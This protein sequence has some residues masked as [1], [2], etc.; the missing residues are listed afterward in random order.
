MTKI[1]DLRKKTKVCVIIP[2]LNEEKAVGEEID[3]VKDALKDYNFDIV[4]SDGRSSDNT[5]KIANQHGAKTIYQKRKGY[6]DALISGYLYS[7]QKLGAEILV[8]IDADGTYDSKD[9]PKMVDKI[10]LG[11]ADYVVGK[12]DVNTKSMTRSHILGNKVISWLIRSLLHVKVSD[13]QCGLF[14]FRSYLISEVEN[15]RTIGW[16]LNT[17]LLTKAAESEMIIQEIETAYTPRIGITHS[18]TLS[19]GAINLAVIIRMIIDFQPLLLLG[20]ISA[21]FFGLGLI[22]GSSVVYEFINSETITRSN[23]ATLSALFIITGIQILSLGIVADMI[24]RKNQKRI[25]PLEAYY[26][27]I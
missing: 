22:I 4:V 24:K 8:N 17:E 6:G 5:V 25:R 12:R 19:G 2:A 27:E 10:L 13:S 7:I 21:V 11:D 15:W 9:I 3:K 20:V 18:N 1:E 26:S 14:A 16:A 23:L